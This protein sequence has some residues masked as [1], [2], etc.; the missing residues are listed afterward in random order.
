MGQIVVAIGEKSNMGQ[1]KG[2][3]ERYTR[4]NLVKQVG[5]ETTRER[6][7]SMRVIIKKSRYLEN[8]HNQ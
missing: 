7:G 6:E 4:I 8:N 2:T 5:R 3:A 1:G